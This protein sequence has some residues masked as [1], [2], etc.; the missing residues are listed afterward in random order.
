MS[1]FAEAPVA[2]RGCKLRLFL[3]STI[4]YAWDGRMPPL[5]TPPHVQYPFLSCFG[6]CESVIC[7]N[8]KCPQGLRRHCFSV[9][10]P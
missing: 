7:M 10:R 8:L 4:T 6:G 1:K 9:A 2:V 5:F 3:D